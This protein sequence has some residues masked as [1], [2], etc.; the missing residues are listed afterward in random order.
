MFDRVSNTMEITDKF[1]NLVTN[2]FM[3]NFDYRGNFSFDT[4]FYKTEFSYACC[5]CAFQHEFF[6]Y[7]AE[8]GT[9]DEDVYDDIVSSIVARRCKHVVEGVP[10]EWVTETSVSGF[11]IDVTVGTD[12][13]E[14]DNM[15]SW[16]LAVTKI[17]KGV[18][19]LSIHNIA[20]M[21]K[22]YVNI[23]WYLNRYL[24]NRDLATGYIY[25]CRNLNDVR[26][27]FEVRAI[28]VIESLIQTQDTNLVQ[29]VITSLK[30]SIL[31]LGLLKAF[32]YT[33]RQRLEDI[34]PILITHA[35]EFP[36]C[37][38]DIRSCVIASVVYSRAD[39]FRWLL[40]YIPETT[41]TDFMKQRLSILCKA[42]KR[43]ECTQI[44]LAHD[45]ELPSDSTDEQTIRVLLGLLDD[46]Y[47]YEDFRDEIVAA[48]NV[49]PDVQR[50]CITYLS[51][52]VNAILRK[53][54]VVKTVIELGPENFSQNFVTRIV[55]DN[56][57]NVRAMLH[58]LV[59]ANV[60]MQTSTDTVKQGLRN[61][62]CRLQ[63][64]DGKDQVIK[65]RV[66]FTDVKERDVFTEEDYDLPMSF[67]GPWLLECGFRVSKHILTEFLDNLCKSKTTNAEGIRRY[68]QEYM[69]NPKQLVVL[70]RDSLRRYYQGRSLQTFL[71]STVCPEK[72]K[73]FILLKHLTKC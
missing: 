69:E 68:I 27:K 70:S 3:Q 11:Q 17:Q 35:K 54:L 25:I 31:G 34:M 60:E 73:D 61:D 29:C 14:E 16:R 48:L 10:D 41:E 65:T 8:D 18:F 21:R 30:G 46:V 1:R 66:Y 72:I 49:I 43:K 52:D 64:W 19:Q 37:K 47:F 2:K 51:K 5:P 71:N 44:L 63:F 38:Y 33:L 23:K 15:R 39:C 53:P 9:I 50:K 59:D 45:R 28:T 13:E 62:L 40:D 55:L 26:G 7:I 57:R 56:D 6:T 20:L 24:N 36:I 58:L 67:T 4:V 32:E 22:K 12:I 42:L